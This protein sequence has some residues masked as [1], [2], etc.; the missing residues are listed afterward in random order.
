MDAEANDLKLRR[1]SEQEKDKKLTSLTEGA[2]LDRLKIQQSFAKFKANYLK[3][4]QQL[5]DKVILCLSRVCN[6]TL[7]YLMH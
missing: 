3:R 2:H 1:K 4:K 6:Y 5:L 7:L